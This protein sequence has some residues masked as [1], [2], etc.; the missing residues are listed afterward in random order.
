[1]VLVNQFPEFRDL[2]TTIKAMNPEVEIRGF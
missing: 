2:L 1:V